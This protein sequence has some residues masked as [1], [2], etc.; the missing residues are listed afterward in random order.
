MAQA[1][2]KTCRSR[3]CLSRSIIGP[4]PGHIAATAPPAPLPRVAAS[5][6]HP[7][8]GPPQVLSPSSHG[9]VAQKKKEKKKKPPPRESQS[10]QSPKRIVAVV[11]LADGRQICAMSPSI[12]NTPSVTNQLEAGARGLRRLQ[13]HLPVRGSAV[14]VPGIAVLRLWLRRIP[15]SMIDGMIELSGNYSSFRPA[16]SRKRPAV[17]HRSSSRQARV[18]GDPV[19]AKAPL[20]APCVTACVP[21]MKAHRGDA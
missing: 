6:V 12:E 21:P 18:L 16:A 4:R 20:Q 5:H 1:N 15:L 3:R 7:R 14:A 17:W 2:W 8:W 11:Q 10:T 13:L 9:R 19:N